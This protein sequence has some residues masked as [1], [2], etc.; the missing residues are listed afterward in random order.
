M[1]KK[2]NKQI[3][4]QQ[5]ARN[6]LGELSRLNGVKAVRRNLAKESLPTIE[7]ISSRLEPEL[8]NI[9]R[10]FLPTMLHLTMVG[11]SRFS[12]KHKS[13]DLATA[14]VAASIPSSREQL[15]GVRLGKLGIYGGGTSRA[16]KLAIGLTSDLVS[17]E[18]AQFETQFASFG[19]P[20]LPEYNQEKEDSGDLINYPAHLSIAY[21]NSDRRKDLEDPR[22]LRKLSMVAGL[23]RSEPT[24]I[25]LDPVIL[26]PS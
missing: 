4:R 22:M 23:I 26:V 24:F 9:A 11:Y 15:T 2:P 19:F 5:V 6:E 20:L 12:N 1:G 7:E 17:A 8:A 21:I 16:P 13:S 3:K 10:L 14:E 25:T 18:I